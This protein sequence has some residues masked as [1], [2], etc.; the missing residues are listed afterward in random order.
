MPRT[1]RDAQLE[2]RAAR[3]RLKPRGDPYYRAIEEGLHLGYRKPKSGAGKWVARFYI[4]KD[5]GY[6]YEPLGPADDY[7][8]A[9]GTIILSYKQAQAL[10]RERLVARARAGVA[11][12]PLTVTDALDLYVK[13]L[14]PTAAQDAMYKRRLIP[15]ELEAREVVS[16]TADEIRGWHRGLAAQGARLR[17]RASE[18]QKH[19]P[20]PEGD[21][22][23]R[24][25]QASANRVLTVLKA[26]LN[27]AF[28]DGK[29]TSDAA[30]RQAKPFKAVEKARDRF[31]TVAEARRLIN[32]ADAELRP[33]VEA[34]LL[35]G[36]RYGELCRLTVADFNPDIGTL[37]NRRTK[38]GKPRHVELTEEGITF[39]EQR[40][41]GRPGNSLMFAKS[42]GSPWGASHQRR[43]MAQA[44]K[45]ANISPAINFHQLRHTWASLSIM[46]GMP[47]LV[48]AH[49]LGHADGRMVERTYG[50]LS[51]DYLRK[52]IREN[53]PRYGISSGSKLAP[54]AEL[55]RGR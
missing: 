29:V 13:T 2:S 19:R 38:T 46:A 17:T 49:N 55:G 30:W 27:R 53:A 50:H 11:R 20:G 8:D 33:L 18:D 44:C 25:R 51:R 9:D 32:A 39:F 21:D 42:D 45:R 35:T 10:A 23:H 34:A 40:S 6:E 12:G 37:A 48:A 4:G 28:Q 47:L 41:A 24:R 31:L 54:L 22:D 26:A 5:A 7:S 1:V 52:A 36:A 15:A 14:S 3:S 16:L 43:R